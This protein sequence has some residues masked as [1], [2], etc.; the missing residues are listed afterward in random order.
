MNATQLEL[1]L[2]LIKQLASA[3]HLVDEHKEEYKLALEC[4]ANSLANEDEQLQDNME[5]CVIAKLNL[6]ETCL[7]LLDSLGVLS[8]NDTVGMDPNDIH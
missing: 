6:I 1:T 3:G 2:K 5:W 8:P 7:N 4:V